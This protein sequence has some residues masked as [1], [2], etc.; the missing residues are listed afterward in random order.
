MSILKADISSKTDF[1][2]N[3]IISIYNE[4]FSLGAYY[5]IM[6]TRKRGGYTN[7]E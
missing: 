5:V 4:Q 2:R 1:F 6:C 7:N 3:D